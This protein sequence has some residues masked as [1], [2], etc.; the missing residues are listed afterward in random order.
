MNKTRWSAIRTELRTVAPAPE[1][2]PA[3][4]FWQQFRAR[5]ALVRRERA[6]VRRPALRTAAWG[7]IPAA[8]A[9]ILL[10]VARPSAAP[11]DTRIKNL[12]IVAPHTSVFIVNLSE[13]GRPAGAILWV[14]GVTGDEYPNG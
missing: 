8:A 1:P 10:L 7:A 2:R 4:P 14:T 11:A 5:A 6:P 9:L 12:E 13:G 3:A